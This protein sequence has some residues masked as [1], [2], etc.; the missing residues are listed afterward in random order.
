M[1]PE[2]FRKAVVVMAMLASWAA[3]SLIAEELVQPNL[4]G[5]KYPALA[6]SARIGGTVQFLVKSDGVQLLSG[7]NLLVPAARGNLEKWAIPYASS[8]PLSVTYVFR[9]TD[10]VTT[11]IVEVDQPVGN[12]FDRFF[13]RLFRRP[14]TRRTKTWDCRPKET[15]AVYKN[16]MKDGLPSIEIE[17][18]SGAMC[19]QPDE[20]AI[21]AL[22]H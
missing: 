8:S 5:F 12:G 21:T 6:R 20:V 16:E 15:P 11:K 22:R 18:G 4:D 13:L 17:I 2:H 3:V 10:E 19:V 9:L 7:H 14:V 1:V